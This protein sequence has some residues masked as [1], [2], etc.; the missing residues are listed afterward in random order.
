MKQRMAGRYPPQWLDELRAR[1]D[2]VKVIG[3]YVTLKKNGHRYV[4]L[5][6]FHNETA[7]SFSVDEQKQVYHCF[8]CKAGGSVIQ[9]VMDIER[10][11][12]PEAVAFLADQLHM[13]LPEMQNDPAYEKRRTLK[14]RIYLANR[15]AA[16][17][18]HQLLL[19]PESS[20]ILHYLQQRGL[21]DAVIRRFG[22]GAAPPSAQVGHRLMEEGFTEEELVQAGLMLRR[23]GRTF[24]MFRNRAMFPI[25][26]T[27]GNVLGFGG[28]AM[29]DAMPKYLNT[30]DTPAFNKRY[31]VFAANLLRK[32]RGLTRVI[33]V[34][35]YMDVVALSQ[36]GVEGVAATLGTALTPEQA[37]LLHR[38]A[39]EV[40]IAYD[41]DR[42]GQKAILRG[43]EV[44]EGENVPV[45][46]L[47]FPGGLDP[48]EF[49]RQEGLEAFQALKPISAVTYRMRR[50]KERHDVSTEEGRIE[51]AKACAAILRGVKEPVELENH[52]RHLSVETGFSKEV[53]MQQIGAAPPPKVVTAAKR[54]GFRQKA[55]EV[56]QVDWTARTLLAVLATGRLPKDSV[57]PEEFED[58]LL[59]SLC[60]GLLAGE[61]AAS[62]M[63]RQTDDQG[64]A[65][66]GDILS[67][68]TDLD[69]DG[70]MRMA[71]DCL[72][73]MR[74]QRL[75]KALD[76]IQQR[77][78]TLA[79]EERERE[80]QRAFALTQQLLD[81]K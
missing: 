36:F 2:I 9:F 8:G 72:K 16:R 54:E 23:E 52:L 81:L 66:V 65:A 5:C 26:D 55:R 46:V 44:L 42:A 45:R 61:S 57:S 19:Q 53:L 10:L 70:L 56:S 25:I 7:P 73:K 39:P 12:F 24:D 3:S 18:Y 50:E 80:T 47:D 17:M 21:S 33:L 22:I 74:K 6:P 67:L 30:S 15:T 27:Y 49:I 78:P 4:G 37:R 59:R 64:R 14:E 51:Y 20:A 58:P 76:L 40:H 29:G 41:G 34:E 38:F 31:T 68:N 48:D 69:D 79:G 11:S 28:R 35:G 63:E 32:A 75:E 77:L 43:L 62:L 71:Q 1:A 60:E 13:P